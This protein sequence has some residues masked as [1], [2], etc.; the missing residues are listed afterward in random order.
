MFDNLGISLAL[1]ASGQL[2]LIAVGTPA[3]P[4]SL[5]DLPTIAETLPAFVSTTWVGAFLPPKTPRTVADRLSADFA[6][7]LRQ[8]DIVQRFRDHGCEPVGGTP[9]ATAAFVRSEAALWK[10][11]IAEA[12]ITAD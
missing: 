11:V 5:P 2:R 7:A 3:R 6:A 4:P 8:P 1:A 12:G 10:R 9:E